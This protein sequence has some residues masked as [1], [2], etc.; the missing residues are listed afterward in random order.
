MRGRII[1]VAKMRA[2]RDAYLEAVSRR[3]K[4]AAR[5]AWEMRGASTDFAGTPTSKLGKGTASPRYHFRCRTIT[6][7]YFGSGDNDIDRWTVASS[8]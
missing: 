8:P 5:A 3:N 6:V 7:A 4:P 2:Q 1:E